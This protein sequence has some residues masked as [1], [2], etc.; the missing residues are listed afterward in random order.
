MMQRSVIT[1]AIIL[2]AAPPLWAA[3][4]YSNMSN[5]ELSDMRGSMRQASEQE[6]N[7]FRTEWQQRAQTM[8]SEERQQYTGRPA[9][10]SADGSNAGQGMGQGRGGGGG[11]GGRR[12]GR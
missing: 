6:R 10:A 7:A 9:N 1:A 12:M 5:Q 2:M 8:S 3:T 4:D 11:G